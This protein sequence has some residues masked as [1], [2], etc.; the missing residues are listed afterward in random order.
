VIVLLSLPIWGYATTGGFAQLVSRDD[1]VRIRDR[2]AAAC[3]VAV[4]AAEVLILSFDG[5]GQFSCLQ[6]LLD[7]EGIARAAPG[8]QLMTVIAV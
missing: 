5:G 8:S 7:S 1:D 2:V 6:P 3:A 4:L